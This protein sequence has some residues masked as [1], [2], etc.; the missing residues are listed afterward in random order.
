[1]SSIMNWRNAS[2]INLFKGI[3]ISV[4]SAH[5]AVALEASMIFTLLIVII[6]F[7]LDLGQLN[8]NRGKVERTVHSVAS[9]IR[10]R[11]YLYDER[12]QVIPAEVDDIAK[13]ALNLLG[14]TFPGKAVAVRLETFYFT[15]SSAGDPV[16][17]NS[18][19]D[20][21]PLTLSYA[22]DDSCLSSDG[23]LSDVAAAKMTFISERTQWG[24][25]PIY[26]VTLC[27]E[28]AG[29]STFLPFIG[30]LIRMPPNIAISSIVMPR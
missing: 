10:E 28:R 12:K 29:T 15:T 2:L 20:G 21:K 8:L 17:D 19:V 4:K 9:V 18:W 11:T 13:V 27:V 30:S 16:V 14:S 24:W 25:V 1:M 23:I 22:T 3:F 6:Y 5:G 26:R 7:V